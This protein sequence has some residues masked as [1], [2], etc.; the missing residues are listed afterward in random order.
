MKKITKI[1]DNKTGEYSKKKLRVAAYC[2][3]STDSD[4][5]L[6]SLE[7]QKRHY[8]SYISSRED[9]I[10][11]GLYF[12]EGIT[13]TKKEKRPELLRMIE[14]CQTGKIDFIITKSIS[15]FSRNTTDCLEMVRALLEMNIPI[16]FEKENLNTGAMESEFFL[17]ILS[18][19]AENESSS[20]SA[21]NKWAIQ[22]RFKNGTYKIS[23]P[24]Y[25]YDWNGKEMVVNPKQAETV[26]WIFSQVLSGK[27]TQSIADE[28]NAKGVTTKRGGHWTATTVRGMLANEKYIG[29]VIFQKTYTDSQFNRHINYGERDRYAVADHHEAIVRREDFEAANALIAQRGK[30]K[31][32]IKGEGKYQNRYC[33]SGKI[34]CGE[35]GDT[36]K[37]RIHT[38]GNYKYVAWCCSTHIS[39]K[40]RCSMKYIRDDELKAA[41][42]TMINKLVFG[43]RLILKPY[44]EALK[45]SGKDASLRRI[46]EIQSLLLENSQQRETLTKLMAQGYIDQILYN[47]ENNTLLSQAEQYRA[48]ISA[49]N[50]SLS[51]DTA[52]VK[53]AS[54]L[55]RFAD[56]GKMLDAF[57]ETLFENTV[58]RIRVLSRHEIALELKCGLTL[59]ERM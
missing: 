48:E 20:I 4:A 36:F 15:R 32:V 23:Y 19:M 40:N 35:C 57:D 9:W 8:E 49:L 12:D 14:D 52:L 24:P 46:Q 39:D 56:K 51:G 42:V 43:R 58:T 54:D 44:F 27:G 31:G 50:Q 53:A 13:G 18:S 6:E 59:K 37:R 1:N 10:F 3:V 47:E 7:T 17:S 21:N 41:F 25:G 55:L 22:N 26:R 33:F 5:Q 34:L 2:R 38:C 16:Y 30:E 45:G 11:A 28:L 29:D